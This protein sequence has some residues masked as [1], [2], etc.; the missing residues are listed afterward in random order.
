[1]EVNVAWYKCLRPAFIRGRTLIMMQ[2]WRVH[3]EVPHKWFNQTLL[4][5]EERQNELKLVHEIS[6]GSLA[7]FL[8]DPIE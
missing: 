8:F 1:M 6:L 3:R 5:T 2:D 4:F 7:T